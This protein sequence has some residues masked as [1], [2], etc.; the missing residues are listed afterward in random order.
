MLYKIGDFS[1]LTGLSIRTLRYYDEIDLF[2]PSE[3][4]LFTNYRYYKESQLKDLELINTLKEVGFTLEEI[5]NNWNRF[6]EKLFVKRKEELLK[7]VE[8][9]NTAIKKVDELRSKINNGMIVDT[10][11]KQDVIKKKLFFKGR[12][13]I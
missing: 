9:K 10:I 7:E 13:I 3:V 5:K 1:K 11:P 12:M 8:F 6:D 2:K 4:D